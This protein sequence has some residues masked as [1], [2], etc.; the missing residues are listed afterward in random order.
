MVI[1]DSVSINVLQDPWLRTLS[2]D[3]WLAPKN[4]S[5][6]EGTMVKDFLIGGDHYKWNQH[7]LA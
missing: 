2:L 4:I 6:I 7:A 1:G 3:R 5:A